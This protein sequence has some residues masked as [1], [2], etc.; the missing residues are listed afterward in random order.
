MTRRNYLAS[1]ADHVRHGSETQPMGRCPEKRMLKPA[2]MLDPEPKGPRRIVVVGRRLDLLPLRWLVPS[3]I[4]RAGPQSGRF[5]CRTNKQSAG[6]VSKIAISLDLSWN[7]HVAL[8][9]CYKVNHFPLWGCWRSMLLDRIGRWI[10]LWS[11]LVGLLK[12][13]KTPPHTTWTKRFI[14]W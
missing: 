9:F 10:S 11:W 13:W 8:K 1:Q 4:L 12:R 6:H 5:T 2:C 3:V 14:W 7:F